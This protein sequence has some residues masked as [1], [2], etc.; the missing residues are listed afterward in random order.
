MSRFLVWFWS[1]G[2]GG[3]LFAAHLAHRLTRDFGADNVTLSM[4]QGDPSL[5]RATS[6]G[7]RT[8]TAPVTSSR[9]KPFATVGGLSQS[10]AVLGEHLH[11]ARAEIII[12]AMNFAACAALAP[13]LDRP[14]VYCMHDPKPHAGDYEI[15]GQQLTQSMVISRA[16]Q[17][18]A[19]SRHSAERVRG[20]RGGLHVAPLSSVFVPRA[21]PARENG[22]PVRLLMLGRMIA[23]KGVD[24]LADAIQRLADRQDW[25]LTIAGAGPALTPKMR[26]RFD[27]ARVDIR[28]EFL[29]DDELDQLIDAHDI[30]LAPYREATQSGVV[31]QALAGGKPIVATPVGALPEQ[32][33]DGRAG[34]LAEAATG[35]AFAAAM[36]AAL[37][38]ADERAAKASGAH[39]LAL[40]AWQ[41]RSW[42]W[43]A[44]AARL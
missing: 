22:G 23:Y 11:E 30:V 34:W 26:A 36:V 8:L 24:I 25:R 40:E 17:V 41:A 32:I 44:D 19:L 43:L 1:G 35:E 21:A 7:V 42:H 29:S 33:G 4:Q 27:A 39:A 38:N 13:M 31:A 5:A 14:L 28:H 37:E 2:G 12:A 15:F 9:R 3:S 18:V 10:A 20:V 6:L 16:I